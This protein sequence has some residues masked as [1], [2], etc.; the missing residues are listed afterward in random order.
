MIKSYFTEKVK[1]RIAT[2]DTYNTKS[3]SESE[4][5]AFIER[6]RK[7]VSVQ[8]GQQLISEATVMIDIVTLK[9]DDEIEFDGR[10]WKILSIKQ[11]RD[12]SARYLSV[13][14]A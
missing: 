2:L 4:V 10:K 12:F 6:K 5:P 8:T 11:E 1:L 13:M 9:L 3:F 14:V 7:W